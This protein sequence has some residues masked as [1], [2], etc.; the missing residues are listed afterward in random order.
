M[1]HVFM[2]QDYEDQPTYSSS[3]WGPTCDGIDCV[4][5]E[6]RLPEL[7][8]EDWLI[9]RDMGAY[10]MCAAS[11]FNG[12]PKPR[13]FYVMHEYHWSVFVELS[14]FVG[15]YWIISC[16][17]SNII[18]SLRWLLAPLMLSL[19]NFFSASVCPSFCLTINFGRTNVESKTC[20][21][22]VWTWRLALG[23]YP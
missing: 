15:L 7:D 9:F 14:S 8:I 23:A 13:C 6:C 3:I 18:Y 21:Y 12:M 16:T 20:P 4:K 2:L 1:K 5:E 19:C 22:V 10:T 17:L 11:T